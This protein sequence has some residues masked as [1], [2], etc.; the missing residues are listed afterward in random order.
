MGFSVAG[1]TAIILG[2]VLFYMGSLTSAVFNAQQGIQDAGHLAER[3]LH[4]ERQGTIAIDNVSYDGLSTTVAVNATN[5]G[6]ITFLADELELLLDGAFST[7]LI[8]SRTVN[9]LATDVWAPA[10]QLTVLATT[11]T[12]PGAVVIVTSSGAA[13]YWRA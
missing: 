3:R 12:D 7:T 4:A 13:A 8:T 6:G 5:T 11:G 1:A 9:G 10:T 2:G